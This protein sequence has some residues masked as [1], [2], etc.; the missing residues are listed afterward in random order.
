MTL[1]LNNSRGGFGLGGGRENED[2]KDRYSELESARG[3]MRID[4]TS[5][6]TAYLDGRC[7]LTVYGES[8]D[9]KNM[10]GE[11]A[12]VENMPKA[13]SEYKAEAEKRLNMITPPSFM[14][15]VMML[16]RS[17][18]Y[19]KAGRA[20]NTST[21]G[22]TAVA[23]GMVSLAARSY[24]RAKDFVLEN[25]GE[26]HKTKLSFSERLSQ[27]KKRTDLKDDLKKLGRLEKLSAAVKA[28]DALRYKASYTRY[29]PK[30]TLA[31]SQLLDQYLRG[32]DSIIR[33]EKDG[34]LEK[35]S[36]IGTYHERVPMKDVEQTLQ[37]TQAAVE[38]IT[39]ASGM[40]KFLKA[41][42]KWVETRNVNDSVNSS[43]TQVL[44]AVVGKAVD[45]YVAAREKKDPSFKGRLSLYSR[46]AEISKRREL[47]KDAVK[48]RA[49]HQKMAGR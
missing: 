32:S 45:S 48:L 5:V 36:W 18:G 40:E 9:A 26:K 8:T 1:L 19:T 11:Y 7:K 46:F 44:S 42:D 6:L 43:W 29:M 27:L 38:M 4:G 23:A 47:E 37:K 25:L 30:K 10:F 17:M 35:R 14:E 39:P 2:I 13:V 16:R 12:K 20:L 15:K 34:S 21:L 49:L 24:G 22:L 28:D 3:G 33:V 31:A 41:A